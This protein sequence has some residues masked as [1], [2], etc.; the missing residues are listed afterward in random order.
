MYEEYREGISRKYPVKLCRVSGMLPRGREVE[1][2]VRILMTLSAGA[3]RVFT[4]VAGQWNTVMLIL[5]N[6]GVEEE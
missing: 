3:V 5:Q 4:H 1:I 2:G 6:R